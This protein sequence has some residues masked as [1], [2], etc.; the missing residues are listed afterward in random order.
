MAV[1]RREREW[2][3]YSNWAGTTRSSS[4]I[5]ARSK[6]AAPVGRAAGDRPD[7]GRCRPG[8]CEQDVLQM[9]SYAV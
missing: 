1:Q 5:W 6:C 7:Q 3:R 4:N 8:W 2:M 9:L